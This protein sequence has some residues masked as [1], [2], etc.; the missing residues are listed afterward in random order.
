MDGQRGA[1]VLMNA[2]T[3]E[4]FVMASHPTFNPVDLNERGMDL[5]KDPDKPL[6][7]RVTQGLYPIGTLI[8]PFASALYPDDTFHPNDLQ[9]VYNAFG[10]SRAPLLRMPL[11]DPVTDKE[12]QDLHITPLQAALASAALS[13]HGT[14]PAPRV[15]TGV[16]TPGGGWVVLPAL[17]TEFEA[18]PGAAAD[19][20]AQSLIDEGQVHW[21]YVG[22]AA[23]GESPVTWFIGG[24]PPN[25]Q[26]SPLVVVVLL[27]EQNPQMAQEI[28]RDLLSAAMNP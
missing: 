10:F 1:V 24:T 23:S 13:N 11:A 5:N 8:E 20:I 14:V 15:A 26:A 3:G 22:E 6:I 21:S 19:A 16:N 12:G 9:S 25:W 4:I 18:I 17:G 27:E 2:N 28:G 7:N